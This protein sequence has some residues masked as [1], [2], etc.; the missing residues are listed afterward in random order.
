MGKEKAPLFDLE[1]PELVRSSFV[2][3][4]PIA[5]VTLET[6]CKLASPIR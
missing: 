1:D 2:G 5:A 3:E 4:L 6:F